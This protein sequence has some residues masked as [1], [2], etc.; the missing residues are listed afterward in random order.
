MAVSFQ[1]FSAAPAQYS[2]IQLAVIL[3][4]KYTINQIIKYRHGNN[5][6]L[7]IAGY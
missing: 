2:R 3:S 7:L 6:Q 4:A 1:L 5:V